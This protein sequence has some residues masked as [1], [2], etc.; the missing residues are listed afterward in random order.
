MANSKGT[1]TRC[2]KCDELQ[3]LYLTALQDKR[4]ILVRLQKELEQGRK[5]REEVDTMRREARQ[6]IGQRR[7]NEHNTEMSTSK[8]TSAKGSDLE[9]RLNEA[10]A[11]NRKWKEEF[12]ELKE[13]Y[14]TET[15][16]LHEEIN[17]LRQKIEECNTHVYALESE[18]TRLAQTL[19]GRD[20]TSRPSLRNNEESELVKFQMQ[21][22]QEDFSCERRDRERAQSEKDSLQEQ[23]NS[24]HEIISTLTQEIEV[25]KVQYDSDQDE[26]R[27]LRGRRQSVP[28]PHLQIVYPVID[29]TERQQET[30]WRRQQQRRGIYTR[31]PTLAPPSVFYGGDVEVDQ[32]DGSAPVITDGYRTI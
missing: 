8:S 26:I 2:A 27:R 32:T 5:L 22:Y 18:N 3:R 13:K 29:P 25:Y 19:S 17:T 1:I 9:R 21:A 20:V 4:T 30:R 31:G 11:V 14:K 24:A 10:M 28:Q 23:L 7:T 16:T 6:A 15:Q 12:E